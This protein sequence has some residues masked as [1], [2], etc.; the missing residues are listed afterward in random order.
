MPKSASETR[1]A[2]YPLARHAPGVFSEG[3]AA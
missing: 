1:Q 2:P 3:D